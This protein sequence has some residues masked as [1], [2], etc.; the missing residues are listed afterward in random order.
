MGF[1]CD[2]HSRRKRA[3]NRSPGERCRRPHLE[4]QRASNSQKVKKTPRWQ[5][6][7]EHEEWESLGR[8]AR[9]RHTQARRFSNHVQGDFDAA[10]DRKRW[11]P[12]PRIKK[13]GQGEKK[14]IVPRLSASSWIVSKERNECL[15][16]QPGGRHIIARIVS[17]SGL[18]VH[19]RGKAKSGRHWSAQS[20]SRKT[21]G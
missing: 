5:K 16:T 11:H 18:D 3:K 12:P 13:G 19:V 7:L 8:T 21:L 17:R 9:R 1:P 14:A 10:S 20:R 2:I 4:I 6:T 15:R